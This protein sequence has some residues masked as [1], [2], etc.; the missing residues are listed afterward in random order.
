M[1]QDVV[2]FANCNENQATR[3]KAFKV[4]TTAAIVDLQ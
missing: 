1:H 4:N 3:Q 2:V